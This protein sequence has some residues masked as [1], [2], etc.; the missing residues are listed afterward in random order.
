MRRQPQVVDT[1][2]ANSQLELRT[3]STTFVLRNTGPG[4]FHV[5]TRVIS[6]VH[7][8][9]TKYD[10]INPGRVSHVNSSGN[11]MRVMQRGEVFMK[12]GSPYDRECGTPCFWHRLAFDNLAMGVPIRISSNHLSP[13]LPSPA[14]S[15]TPTPTDSKSQG[16]INKAVKSVS[17][18]QSSTSEIPLGN[19]VYMDGVFCSYSCA[20]AYII[21]QNETKVKSARDPNLANSLV[22]LKQLFEQE[23]PGETLEA[24]WDWRLLKTVGSGN[25]SVK[26]YLMRIK[27]VRIVPNYNYQYCPIT[28]SYDI[29]K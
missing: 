24:A 25:M 27:G 29:L 9:K 7:E 8:S 22:L 5:K 2:D 18:V 23:F 6:N 14:A 16:K 4:D 11:A 21:D 12:D 17:N 10:I 19:K 15:A 3:M 20:Y 28:A 1:F 26:E 13:M